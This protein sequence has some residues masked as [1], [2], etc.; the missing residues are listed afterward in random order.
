MWN[1][2]TYIFPNFDGATVEVNKY[3]LPALYLTCD[4]LSMSGLKLNHFSKGAP[5]QSYLVPRLLSGPY[6]SIFDI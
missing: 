5:V 1:E 2:I 4:Y 3:F 6:F